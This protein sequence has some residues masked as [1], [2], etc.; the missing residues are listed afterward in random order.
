MTERLT[1][2]AP[3]V[4]VAIPLHAS[5]PWVDNIVGNIRR[6]P[7]LVTEI[8]VSDRTVV[9]DAADQLRRLLADDHRVVVRSEALDLGWPEH[10]QLLM[11]EATGD[12]F[13]WMPH[14]DIFEPSWIPVLDAALD[15]HPEAW[16]AF[17]RIEPVEAD[18]V[19]PG[20]RP[21][22]HP[23]P[24]PISP[25]RAAHLGIRGMG[26]AFRGL[27]RRR[28]V[29][30]AGVRVDNPAGDLDDPAVDIAWVL[31]VALRSGLVFD[32]RTATRKRYYGSSTSAQW[33]RAPFSDVRQTIA[34]TD[35][36]VP[37]GREGLRLRALMWLGI[38]R[39]GVRRPIG[40]AINPA[41]DR[42]H[43]RRSAGAR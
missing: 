22:Y 34:V 42:L 23:R 21:P 24:G 15:R 10:F 38:A 26:V 2:Q 16:I 39:W 27:V 9:D 1:E 36:A 17:G 32:D 5:A 18:G 20:P 30:A 29:I 31:A 37:A 8:V 40:M 11:E 6:L 41:R 19:S 25:A 33:R 35:A 13:M 14:D 7:D 12:R 43:R 3:G 28:E 4:S